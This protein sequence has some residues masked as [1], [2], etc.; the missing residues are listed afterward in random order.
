M[1]PHVIWSLFTMHFQSCFVVQDPLVVN[2]S[3]TNYVYNHSFHYKSD[4]CDLR[5][6]INYHYHYH[7][8]WWTSSLD[9]FLKI[10]HKISKFNSRNLISKLNLQHHFYHSINIPNQTVLC[11]S[12]NKWVLWKLLAGLN[13]VFHHF[14]VFFHYKQRNSSLDLFLKI[15]HKISKFNSRN[16]ILKLNLQHHFYHSINIPDQ[17]VL[18]ISINKQVLWTLLAGRNHVFI[19]LMSFSI[20]SREKG[21]KYMKRGST[22]IKVLLSNAVFHSKVYPKCL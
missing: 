8:S 12:I 18:C 5:S 21:E 9:L 16:L 22:S 3:T 6:W 17:T 1:S 7:R 4:P 11:I 2:T 15:I 20:T 10:I 13:H 19:I 14:N